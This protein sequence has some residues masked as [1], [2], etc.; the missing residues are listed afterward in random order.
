MQSD[1]PVPSTQFDLTQLVSVVKSGTETETFNVPIATIVDKIRSGRFRS[2]I[3]RIRTLVAT[4]DKPQANSL[5]IKLPAILWSGQF[6]RRKAADLIQHSGLI[7][8]DFDDLGDN[9]QSVRSKLL[10]S[11]HLLLLFISPSGNG[12]K[13]VF[14]VSTDAAQHGESFNAVAQHVYELTGEKIDS[15][16]KDVSRLC[17]V[18]YDPEIFVNPGTVATLE[19]PASDGSLLLSDGG[20]CTDSQ[21]HRLLDAQTHRTPKSLNNEPSWVLEFLPTKAHETNAVFFKMGRKSRSIEL[22]Q[23]RP[24]SSQ[25]LWQAFKIWFDHSQP[26]F[27]SESL[28]SYFEEFC[29]IRSYVRTPLDESQLQLAWRRANSEPM[30]PESAHLSEPLRLLLAFCAQLQL[31]AGNSPFYLSSHSA[32][33]FFGVA[34]NQAYRWLRSLEGHSHL[35]CEKR[36]DPARRLATEY[37]Y[38][39]SLPTP[40]RKAL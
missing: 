18:S 28:Q 11:P 7:V 16:G 31:M 21:T 27:L 23:G 37:R 29:R 13:A 30:P 22:S 33:E 34:P 32:A 24:L 12:L 4:G 1:T 19:I 25:E 8:A 9:L 36:G 17:F 2:E 39:G 35:R 26:E 40:T 20:C 38:T 10:A 15:S 5:K 6:K 3:E 14:R